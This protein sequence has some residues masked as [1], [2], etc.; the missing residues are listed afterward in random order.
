MCRRLA[1]ALLSSA[2]LVG[3]FG[4]VP[5]NAQPTVDGKAIVCGTFDQYGVNAKSVKWI[6][7][8]LIDRAN[9]TPS[10]AGHGLDPVWWTRGQA[11]C[12]V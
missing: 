9:Q 12:A 4:T 3:A 8:Y 1:S 10:G 2:V 6:G 11:A 5:A 7:D